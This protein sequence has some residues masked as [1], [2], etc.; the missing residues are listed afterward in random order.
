MY[1]ILSAVALAGTVGLRAR[2]SGGVF[3]GVR[4]AR[5]MVS[6]RSTTQELSRYRGVHERIRAAGNCGSHG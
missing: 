5:I 4:G 1:A 2:C 6:V 3:I